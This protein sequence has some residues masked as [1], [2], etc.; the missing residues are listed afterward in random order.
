M[1][2]APPPPCSS[3]QVLAR[4]VQRIRVQRKQTKVGFLQKSSSSAVRSRGGK[5]NAS[6]QVVSLQGRDETSSFKR[7]TPVVWPADRNQE[8]KETKR[9]LDRLLNR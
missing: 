3:L 8:E 4:E 5:N 2:L 6:H 9:S 1:R 7:V